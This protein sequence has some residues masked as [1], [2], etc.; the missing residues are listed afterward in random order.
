METQMDLPSLLFGVGFQ[1]LY[2]DASN[3]YV[4]SWICWERVRLI[5]TTASDAHN[6][7]SPIWGQYGVTLGSLWP[8]GGNT[9]E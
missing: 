2:S 8:L 5:A 9:K 6:I 3:V 7:V 4:L 1:I